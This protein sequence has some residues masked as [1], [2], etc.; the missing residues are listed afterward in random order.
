MRLNLQRRDRRALVFLGVAVVAYIVLAWGL[1]PFYGTLREAESAAVEKEKLLQKYR[2]VIGR[3]D[4]YVSLVAEVDNQ[5]KQAEE[6][7]IRSANP[8]LAAVELQTIVE[9]TARKLDIALIQRSVAP[10]TATEDPIRQIT[11]T[12][13]FEATPRQLVSLLAELRALPKSIRVL[14][15]TVNPVQT[16]Q[17]APKDQKFSK[18]LRV[19]MSLGAWIETVATGGQ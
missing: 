4:R 9:G 5:M 11:M 8:S 2:E 7:I 10:A 17:E 16:A 12:I 18:N 1:L 6:R 13:A 15:M 14:T 3:K 19:G